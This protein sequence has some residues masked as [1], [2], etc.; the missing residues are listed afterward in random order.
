MTGDLKYCNIEE[1]HFSTSPLK[2]STLKVRILIAQSLH[3]SLKP[4]SMVSPIPLIL[5]RKREILI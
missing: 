2:V 1:K 4:L 5:W 3:V